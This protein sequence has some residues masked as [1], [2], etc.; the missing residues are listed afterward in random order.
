[1]A[2]IGPP[3]YNL[4]RFATPSNVSKLA[5]HNILRRKAIQPTTCGV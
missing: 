1:M 4:R 2:F 5:K 3:V